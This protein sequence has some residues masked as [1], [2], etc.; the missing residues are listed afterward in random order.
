MTATPQSPMKQ[1]PEPPHYRLG[2]VVAA[3]LVFFVVA[4]LFSGR[5]F[6]PLGG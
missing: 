4:A 5:R 2:E 3:V 6:P 1:K